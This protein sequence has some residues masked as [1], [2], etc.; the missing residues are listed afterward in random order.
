MKNRNKQVELSATEAQSK[1]FES[2][3]Y[4]RRVKQMTEMVKTLRDLKRIP[5]RAQRPAKDLKK[6]EKFDRTDKFRADKEA[7]HFFMEPYAFEETRTARVTA[8]EKID[9]VLDNKNPKTSI[10]Y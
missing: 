2:P 4:R 5:Y 3:N 6:Q 1:R 10:K 8:S 7:I 9:E